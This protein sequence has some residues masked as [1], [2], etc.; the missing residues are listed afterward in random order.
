MSVNVIVLKSSHG[1]KKEPQ[2]TAQ[3]AGVDEGYFRLA[4]LQKE[5]E[6]LTAAIVKELGLTEGVTSMCMTSHDHITVYT[7]RE[8]RIP[9]IIEYCEKTHPY[10]NTLHQKG[11]VEVKQPEAWF[12]FFKKSQGE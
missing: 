9:D 6:I 7:E 8:E 2:K 5:T 11:C 3:D 1:S 12:I 10:L 4:E